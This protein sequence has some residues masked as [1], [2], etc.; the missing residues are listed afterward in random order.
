[1]AVR[2]P[3]RAA[4]QTENWQKMGHDSTLETSDIVSLSMTIKLSEELLVEYIFAFSLF[5][6]LKNVVK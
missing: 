1:M 4:N 6:D 3:R 2:S 5:Q